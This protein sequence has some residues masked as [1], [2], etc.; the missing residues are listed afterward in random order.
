MT[1]YTF[2]AKVVKIIKIEVMA[3]NIE[4]AKKDASSEFGNIVKDEGYR[5]WIPNTIWVHGHPDDY[6]MPMHWT[7][8]RGD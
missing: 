1:K 7:T 8:C 5:E 6:P 2:E 3:D 4:A